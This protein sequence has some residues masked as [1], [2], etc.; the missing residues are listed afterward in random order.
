MDARPGNRNQCMDFIK[1]IACVC[2]VFMH[3]EFPGQLGIVVQAASRF[4]VP[5]FFMV[6]GFYCYRND[7]DKIRKKTLHILRITAG[8]SLFYVLFALLQYACGVKDIFRFSL[9]DIGVFAVFNA[10]VVIVS[11]IWFLYALLYDYFLF[12]LAVRTGKVKWAQRMIP[13]LALLYILFAQGAVLLG[14]HIPKVLYKNFLVEG[15]TFFMLGHWLHENRNKVEKIGNPVLYAVIAGSTLL[16]VAERY[17]MGRDFGV[18][19]FSFPQVF[20]IFVYA[21]NNPSAHSGGCFQK[22]GARCSMFVYILHPF[23]WHSLEYAYRW[24]G[25]QENV[26]ALYPLPL[27]VLSMSISLS[28]LLTARK[29]EA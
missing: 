15:F 29:K 28:I 10:P 6:S 26:F 9:L 17:F 21:M 19:I 24:A 18:N 20:C 5:F 25:V 4:C 22:L 11:Q 13:A 27:L 7:A 12:Y 16:C 2:V 8:A 1:G 3:C 23:V 14:I